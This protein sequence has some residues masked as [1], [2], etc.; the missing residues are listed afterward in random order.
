MQAARIAELLD[1][2]LGRAG[3]PPLTANDL[4]HISTYIDILVRWNSRINL[5]AIRDP[6]EIVTRHFGESLFAASHLFPRGGETAALGRRAEPRSRAESRDPRPRGGE[7]LG[8]G[9]GTADLQREAS[10]NVRP[11]S[12]PGAGAQR[13]T[14]NDRISVADLGSGAGFPGVPLKLWAPGLQLTLIESNQKKS[15]FLREIVRSLTLTDVDIQTARA[16]TLP[17]ASFDVVTL[18][19]AERFASVLPIAGAL[20]KPG[21]RL[22]LL[23]GSAQVERAR[24]LLPDRAWVPPL[25]IP[26][27]HSRVLLQTG[28]S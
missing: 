11:A 17:P 2:F 15:I 13:P 10:P 7:D 21:G 22:A 5:T 24:S 23:I 26:G 14:T 6:E 28:S 9:H 19:A 20:A 18:R 4:E 25:P 3:E 16:E 27:S 8:S 12:P 1:P